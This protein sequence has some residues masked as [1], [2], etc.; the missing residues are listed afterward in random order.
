MI[1]YP[2]LFS[3]GFNSNEVKDK[4][5]K[6]TGTGNLSNLNNDFYIFNVLFKFL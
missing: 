3:E 2:N 6:T 1:T 5:F 4:M